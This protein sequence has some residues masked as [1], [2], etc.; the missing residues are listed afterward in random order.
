MHGI[1]RILRAALVVEQLVLRL[2]FRQFTAIPAVRHVE[3]DAAA[4]QGS[5]RSHLHPHALRRHVERHAAVF[6]EAYVGGDQLVVRRG[7]EQLI[8][9][10][11]FFRIEVA[12]FHRPDAIA[13]EQHRIA[14]VE[15]ARFLA[16]QHD[17]QPLGVRGGQRRRVEQLIVV[18]AVFALAARLQFDISAGQQRAQP[19]DAFTADLR[20]H[21]PEGGVLTQ[22]FLHAGIETRLHHHLAQIIAQRDGFH[23]ADVHAAAFD[24]GFTRFQPF[25]RRGDQRHHRPLMAE[26]VKQ[27][28]GA[29]QRG[30]DGNDPHRRPAFDLLN[31]CDAMIIFRHLAAPC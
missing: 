15:L 7:D 18:F 6:P 25:R 16:V 2:L 27:D 28:P 1:Q 31:V 13:A 26:V 9:H 14:G 20:L 3:A 22:Q 12:G 10:G 19:G 4:E 29:D 5:Q 24:F 17:A 11:A 21:H 23:H 8:A 30:H